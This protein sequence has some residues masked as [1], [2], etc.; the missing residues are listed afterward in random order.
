MQGG[1]KYIIFFGRS[2]KLS[3]NNLFLVYFISPFAH[4][5][6]SFWWVCEASTHNF[7][8]SKSCISSHILNA[9]SLA[10]E[11]FNSDKVFLWNVGSWDVFSIVWY[12]VIQ[13]I[14]LYCLNYTSYLIDRIEDTSGNDC[15]RPFDQ[16]IEIMR[17]LFID[18]SVIVFVKKGYF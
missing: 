14:T 1:Y 15:V 4:N 2:I 11:V 17:I 3:P 10:R 13:S 5:L 12:G 6:Q 8:K 18:Y 7:Q 16:V 9:V